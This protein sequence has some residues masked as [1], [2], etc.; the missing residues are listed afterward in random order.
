MVGHAVLGMNFYKWDF[1]GIYATE[2]FLAIGSFCL[3]IYFLAIGSV[4]RFHVLSWLL[5]LMVIYLAASLL[6]DR[7]LYWVLR[8]GVLLLYTTV[9]LWGWMYAR[10][11]N[12]FY[13]SS[14]NPLFRVFLIFGVAT[15]VIQNLG[16]IPGAGHALFAAFG[17][18][19]VG[20]GWWVLSA[21]KL[22]DW[23]PRALLIVGLTFFYLEI[24]YRQAACLIIFPVALYLTYPRLRVLLIVALLLAIPAAVLRIEGFSDWN[25]IWRYNYW[26]AL[27]LDNIN[28]G[29]GGIGQGFGVPHAP[30]SVAFKLW[31]IID[32]DTIPIEYQM[33]SAQPHNGLLLLF[34]QLGIPAVLLFLLP[35]YHALK[36]LGLRRVDPQLAPWL[37]AMAVLLIAVMAFPT[38][39]T[40]FTA[41]FFFWCYG[42]F[43]YQV[44]RPKT[45][46]GIR[47]RAE[48]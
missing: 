28:Y 34:K 37:M 30:L 15:Y 41:V 3:L 13:D 44:Y 26:S 47:Q 25:A 8:H 35:A 32:G 7:D 17:I 29:L 39:S 14:D 20:L 36:R 1:Y 5:G 10:W 33:L 38:L 18:M 27:I 21:S 42:A 4:P 12:R 19:I 43:V 16:L 11:A 45:N 24:T 22:G 9:G 46:T 23:V 2:W 31:S 6:T 40:P 48:H